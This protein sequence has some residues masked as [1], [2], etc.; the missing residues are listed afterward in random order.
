MG[1]SMHGVGS[2]TLTDLTLTL[3]YQTEAQWAGQKT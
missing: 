2:T 3:P 1:I